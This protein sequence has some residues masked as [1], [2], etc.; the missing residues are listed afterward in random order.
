MRDINQF[1]V[2]MYFF[3]IINNDD[4]NL[5]QLQQ[6]DSQKEQHDVLLPDANANDR[7]ANHQISLPQVLTSTDSNLIVS[8][9]GNNSGGR[10]SDIVGS[11]FKCIRIND[12][13]TGIHND[14]RSVTST[15]ETVTSYRTFGQY[16]Q[17]NFIATIKEVIIRLVPFLSLSDLVSLSLTCTGLASTNDISVTS[18]VSAS[19]S[20]SASAAATTL[21]NRIHVRTILNTNL[22]KVLSRFM[23]TLEEVQVIFK[24]HPGAILSGSS[25]LQAYLG[26]Q[27][28][29]YDL[30]FYI[31]L[32]EHSEEFLK[33]TLRTRS[34]E[35]GSQGTIRYFDRVTP[36]ILK[37]CGLPTNQYSS[38][39]LKY[40][41]YFPTHQGFILELTQDQVH[42]TINGKEKPKRI[43]FIFVKMGTRKYP[44]ETTCGFV[45]NTFD[46]SV[47]KSFYDGNSFHTRCIKDIL[48][49]TMTLFTEWF[50]D[51]VNAVT[52]LRIIKYAQWRKIQFLGPYLQLT[53]GAKEV[54]EEFVKV[55]KKKNR[56]F[57][58]MV[59]KKPMVPT[60][61]QVKGVWIHE[62]AKADAYFYYSD[63]DGSG[64]DEHI[65]NWRRV[66]R[67]A[68][69]IRMD[70]RPSYVLEAHLQ[71]HMPEKYAL[72]RRMLAPGWK[73]IMPTKDQFD[74]IWF[75]N[76][77]AAIP[78]LLGDNFEE[79][80]E[81]DHPADHHV[82]RIR[83]QE[84]NYRRHIQKVPDYELETQLQNTIPQKYTDVL[85]A[86]LTSA[87]KCA[88]HSSFHLV[89]SSSSTARSSITPAKDE[90][91]K[92]TDNDS[93]A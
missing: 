51:K 35:Y 36:K 21:R 67:S 73:P 71:A 2:F 14:G 43:Q 82:W 10:G 74:G 20:T 93:V 19:T 63:S 70:D 22:Q 6:F 41:E 44:P 40:S 29:S 33:T 24:T 31:P 86:L 87:N 84:A 76:V 48:N 66:R 52:M 37:Y 49:R 54:Y 12:C 83:F 28:E 4:T 26:E 8:N 72:H 42:V 7:K 77:K 69:K 68:M 23:L 25:I 88:Q 53:D 65:S 9:S 11:G 64:P 47:V 34:T 62:A 13:I 58:Y 45:I 50:V 1:F 92:S 17:R 89:Q 75:E 27:Y 90:L 60:E 56:I 59:E 5:R 15:G 39:Y 46:L 16:W 30:D 55:I 61:E 78:S 38:F 80:F 85:D 91:K 79:S 81:D 18:S 32:K 3:Q 57:S